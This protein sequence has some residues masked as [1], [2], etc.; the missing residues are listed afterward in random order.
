MNIE[1]LRKMCLGLP[2]VTEDI[3]WGHDL[4]FCIGEKMFC[5][6]GIEGPLKVSFKVKD[7]EFHDMAARPHIVPAPYV[8]RYKWVLVEEPH[9]LNAKEW[10]HYVSQ[11]YSLVKENLSKKVLDSFRQNSSKKDPVKR[12]ASTKTKKAVPKKKTALKKKKV[13]VKKKK[14][15]R[16]S[17]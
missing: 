2:H 17:R 16:G 4:C 3:K 5:V 1:D 9:A 12:K 13:T 11:S 8:A 6:T 7:E 10:E 15:G 14:S